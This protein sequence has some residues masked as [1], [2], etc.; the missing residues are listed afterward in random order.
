MAHAAPHCQSL[1]MIRSLSDRRAYGTQAC[2]R[3]E[4]VQSLSASGRGLYLPKQRIYQTPMAMATISAVSTV[5]WTST[6]T[7]RRPFLAP[8]LRFIC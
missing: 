3:A 6:K 5:Y 2:Q 4:T 7:Q 8:S 1:I